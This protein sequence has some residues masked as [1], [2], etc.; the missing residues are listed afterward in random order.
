VVNGGSIKLWRR[1]LFRLWVVISVLWLVVAGTFATVDWRNHPMPVEPQYCK[2]LEP[3]ERV[4]N[5]EKSQAEGRVEVASR[6]QIT[7]VIVI[8]PPLMMLVFWPGLLVGCDWVSSSTGR[9]RFAL[10]QNRR[11]AGRHIRSQ[12]LLFPTRSCLSATLAAPALYRSIR[13][14]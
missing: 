10:N 6:R 7:G 5:C 3:P 8:A 11:A 1:G 2:E 9:E 12:V 4:A 13:P 14:P